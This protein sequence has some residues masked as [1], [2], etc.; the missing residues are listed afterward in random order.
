M[1]EIS[2]TLSLKP[3]NLEDQSFLISLM[4][5]IYPQTYSHLWKDG[6]AWYVKKTYSLQ[7]LEKELSEPNTEYFFVMYQKEAVGILR[8]QNGIEYPGIPNQLVTRLHRIYLDNSVH[9]RRIGQQLLKWV[10]GK[11]YQRGESLLLLEGM[12][13]QNQALGFYEKMGFEN[14][15]SYRLDY[16]LMYKKY[17][18]MFRL[19]KKVGT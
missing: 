18:G 13:T 3:I 14:V 19:C 5:R 12:D 17:R 1:V 16:E 6:G 7:N 10:E 4:N 2:D 15:G 11:I 9:G 8:I